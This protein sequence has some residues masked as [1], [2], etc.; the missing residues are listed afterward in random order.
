MTNNGTLDLNTFSDTINGLSGAG[1]VD[2]VAGGAP[3]LTVGAGNAGSAFSGV[4]K[5]TAGTLS[6]A[7]TGS[8]AFVLS[9][10]N[11][12]TGPTTIANGTLLVTGW[13]GTNSLFVNTNATLGGTGK[14][15][16]RCRSEAGRNFAPG[17]GVGAA[18]A[19]LTLGSNLMLDSGSLTTMKVHT[20]NKN[21]QA[22]SSGAVTYGGA[23]VLTTNAGDPPFAWATHSFCSPPPATPATSPA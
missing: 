18:G 13:I 15:P 20:G 17:A 12:Y 23:L 1:F 8:G 5:N 6:L 4:I 14:M 16:A 11:T 21:D 9:G 10:S 3:T 22:V 7:K 19:V 2:T